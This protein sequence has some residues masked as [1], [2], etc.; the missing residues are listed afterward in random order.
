LDVVEGIEDTRQRAGFATK[1]EAAAALILGGLAVFALLLNAS[2]TVSESDIRRK[3]PRVAPKVAKRIL[4]AA[5][6]IERQM[7]M[8]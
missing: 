4:E 3:A 2:S 7:A 5:Q 8:R 1:S 6:A